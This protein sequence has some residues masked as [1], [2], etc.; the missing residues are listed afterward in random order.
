MGFLENKKMMMDGEMDGEIDGEIDGDQWLDQYERLS[1]ISSNYTKEPPKSIE[2]FHVFI[3]V[4]DYIEKIE[5]EH[6]VFDIQFEHKH[7]HDVV[8]DV[9]NR[10]ISRE[11]VV[12][13]IEHGK[14]FQLRDRNHM[15]VFNRGMEHR[16]KL[17]DILVY[18][19][20][21]E[22]DQIQSY[23]KMDSKDD[24]GDIGSEFL[25]IL[26][27]PDEIVIEPSIFI[28]HEVNAVYF[29]FKELDR[30]NGIKTGHNH[31][32]KSILKKNGTVSVNKGNGHTG[33]K[34]RFTKRVVLDQ[35]GKTIYNRKTKRRVTTLLKN[36][37]KK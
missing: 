4:N 16:Y 23:A 15:G 6:F 17:M 37:I 26:K 33:N 8:S 10:I 1:N 34:V 31:T 21:L 35:R 27:M 19:V 2:I 20:N 11:R 32:L 30:E 29:I 5:S 12:Q 9:P 3:N 22:T 36:C 25:R 28:F 14:R 24:I 18:N 13:M 7:D